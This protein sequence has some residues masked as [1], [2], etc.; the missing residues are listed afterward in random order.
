MTRRHGTLAAFPHQIGRPGLAGP[1][2]SPD[3]VHTLQ[4]SIS[5][6]LVVYLEDLRKVPSRGFVMDAHLAQQAQREHRLVC[7]YL[8]LS[9]KP[10]PFSG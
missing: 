10:H 8:H 3:D 2:L 6:S 5:L 7:P 4:S 1:R 9:T